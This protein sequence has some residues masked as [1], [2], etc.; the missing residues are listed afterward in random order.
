MRVRVA[1]T[2][3]LAAVTVERP[4]PSLETGLEAELLEQHH[5]SVEKA[6]SS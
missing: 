6:A 5:H 4:P 3:D 1:T 2:A